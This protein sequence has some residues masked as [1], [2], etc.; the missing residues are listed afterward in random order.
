[1][2]LNDLELGNKLETTTTAESAFSDRPPRQH[3]RSLNQNWSLKYSPLTG[4]FEQFN[5]SLMERL[6]LATSKADY[7]TK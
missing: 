4:D 2:S 7:Y 1:M 3:L 5:K 6:D